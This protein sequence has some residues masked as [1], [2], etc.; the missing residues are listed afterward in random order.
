MNL[1]LE[2][3]FQQEETEGARA[4][5]VRWAL[6]S[7]GIFSVSS[8]RYAI[9]DLSLVPG[10]HKEFVWSNWVPSRV[11]VLA[12]RVFHGR[13]PT[14]SNLEK[15]GLPLVSTSCPLCSNEVEDEKHLFIECNISRKVL[16]DICSW[17]GTNL[18]GIESVDHL[19]NWGD[20][21]N[22]MGN[23]KAAFLGIIYSYFWSIWKLRN[24]KLFHNRCTE[25]ELLL[26]NQVQALSFFWFKNGV[27]SLDLR[28]KWLEWCCFPFSCL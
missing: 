6:S 15:R 20:K 8:V 11:N 25:R 26:A 9:D 21:L 18:N 7:S 5:D 12:W 2:A 16:L 28:N 27:K 10:D 24:G 17:W 3:W 22:L 13:L 14:K 4:G 23:K 1:P 19:L